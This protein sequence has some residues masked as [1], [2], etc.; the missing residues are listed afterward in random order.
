M[1]AHRDELVRACAAAALG[2]IA[3]PDA[4]HALRTALGD[5]SPRVRASAATAIGRL[6]I[7]ETSQWGAFACCALAFALTVVIRKASTATALVPALTLTLFF[8]SGNFFS[9]DGAPAGLRTAASVFPVR[10][11]YMAMLTAFNPNV[12]GT[13]FALRD[14]GMLALWG[15][16]RAGPRG[17]EV[18]VDPGTRRVNDRLR[19][20]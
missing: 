2:K 18:Q 19:G 10:H 14:L 16:R 6:N 13:G 3:D 12:A 5:I 7:S 17:L 20:G 1:L 4:A 8:L 9:L 11:F 15:G